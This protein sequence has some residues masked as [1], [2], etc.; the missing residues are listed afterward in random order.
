M[1][2]I[3]LVSHGKFAP[4]LHSALEMLAGSGREDILSTSLEDG[5]SQDV[6]E[7]N[8]RKLIAP[9]TLED[10]VILMGDLVGGSPLTTATN[11]IADVGMLEKTVIY[12]GMNL[13]LAVNAA[14][15]K[16]SM[17]MVDL[18]AMLVEEAREEVKEFILD[19]SSED[20][21]V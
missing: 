1:K 15:L 8:F 18:K 14:L 19:T 5:M 10:E 4:G 9:I 17:E 20:E 13:P 3:I 11:V 6:F 7:V 16:D 21:E 2:Y 12:G